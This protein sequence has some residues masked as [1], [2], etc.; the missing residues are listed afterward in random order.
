MDPSKI[1]MIAPTVICAI[2]LLGQILLGLC[3]CV[4]KFRSGRQEEP[5]VRSSL[6]PVSSWLKKSMLV[7]R[8]RFKIPWKPKP[9]YKPK[10]PKKI[11]RHLNDSERLKKT[12]GLL[13]TLER[14]HY[15]ETE[16]IFRKSE[17]NEKEQAFCK[18]YF[19]KNQSPDI[20][21]DQINMPK[22]YKIIASALKKALGEMDEKFFRFEDLKRIFEEKQDKI[23]ETMVKYSGKVRAWQNIP[24]E[25]TKKFKIASTDTINNELSERY[26]L[27]MEKIKEEFGDCKRKIIEHL[28]GEHSERC[29]FMEQFAAY[30]VRYNLQHSGDPKSKHL[31]I[32]S[33]STMLAPNMVDVKSLTLEITYEIIIFIVIIFVLLGYDDEMK[34]K[35]TERM[36]RNAERSGLPKTV[37]SKEVSGD[38]LGNPPAASVSVHYYY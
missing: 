9:K 28:G 25:L 17:A 29:E 6:V 3:V 15:E 7:E 5:K 26:I 21:L 35:Y 27:T 32:F 12:K 11:T 2:V 37:E 16:E 1:L 13:D 31:D 30:A 18:L 23:K 36:H 14:A 22:S 10:K 19:A 4:K 24:D 34:Q 20:I 8:P 38:V 33:M